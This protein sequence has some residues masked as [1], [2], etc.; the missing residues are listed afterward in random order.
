MLITIDPTT[1]EQFEFSIMNGLVKGHTDGIIPL[2]R[3]IDESPIPLPVVWECKC[4]GSKGW[5]SAVKDKLRTSHPK[6]FN[7]GQLYAGELGMTGVLFT[8]I[9]ADTMELHHELVIYEPQVHANMIARAQRIIQ[10][11]EAREILPRGFDD[12][13]VW[14]CKWCRYGARCWA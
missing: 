4:L 7:Q 9:N 13:T 14:Q 10:A 2:W 6:Y 11:N 1:G 3:G 12:P 8:I 5:K